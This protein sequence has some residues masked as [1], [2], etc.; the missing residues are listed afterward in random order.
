MPNTQQKPTAAWLAVF[1]PQNGKRSWGSLVLGLVLIALACGLVWG[2][3]SF[4]DASQWV[5]HTNQ[6]RLDVENILVAI[7]EAESAHRGYVLSG[8]TVFRRQSLIAQG[9]AVDLVSDL[10]FVIMDNEAQR[11]RR[12]IAELNRQTV[13]THRRCGAGLSVARV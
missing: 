4:K 8:D 1:A 3:R 11:A 5:V 12:T 2:A 13:S 7:N 6:A 10:S 9:K